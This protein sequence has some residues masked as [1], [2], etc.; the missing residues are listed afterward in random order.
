MPATLSVIVITY[1]EEENIRDCLESVRWADEVLVVDS[2]SKD[3]TAEWAHEYTAHV[4]QH[5][6]VNAALQRNWAM[7]QATGDWVFVLDAD[8]RVPP[9]LAARIQGILSG[10]TEFDGF[11]VRRRSRFLGKLIRHCGWHRD[12]VLR[13][14]RKGAGH[15]EDRQAHERATVSGRLGTIREW[16]LHDTYRSFEQYFFKCGR[17]TTWGAQDLYRQ[18]KRATWGR[19]TLRPLWRFFRMF[20]LNHGFL[21]GKRGLILCTL[22]AYSVFTKYAK[23]WDMHRR[24]A[25]AEGD[26]GPAQAGRDKA[27]DALAKMTEQ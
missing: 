8:E 24:A 18:G 16:L 17:H 6:F 12:Y 15:Y 5:E 20:V 14:W 25:S 1:N 10:G 22:A 9:E 21:D 2:Y 4:L 23:L 11:H 27:Q 7:T 3:R 13:L 26:G 19:L